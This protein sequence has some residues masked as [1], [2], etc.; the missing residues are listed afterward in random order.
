MVNSYKWKVKNKI[1]KIIQKDNNEQEQEKIW[2]QCLTNQ[3]V[4]EVILR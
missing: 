3:Y 2:L 1:Y 4:E